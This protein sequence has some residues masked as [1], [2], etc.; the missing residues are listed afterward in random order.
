MLDTHDDGQAFM[1][2]INEFNQQLGDEVTGWKGVKKPERHA[3]QD[4]Y[5]ILEIMD[6]ERHAEQL[7]A[8]LTLNNKGDSW[9]YLPVGPF[10][11]CGEF[12]AWLKKFCSNDSTLAYVVLDIKSRLPVGMAGYLRIEPVHGVIEVGS[13]HYSKSFQCTAAATEAM[14]LMMA[15]VFD[16]LHYRRYEW[17]CNALNDA[18]RKAAV[19]LGFQFEGIF[20]QSNVFKKRNRDTAWYSIIDSEWPDIK[21]KLQRWLSPDNFDRD[22]RQIKKLG[23]ILTG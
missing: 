11:D 13:I 20:R 3:M 18:S 5:C 16:E 2:E 8:A 4:Q 23:E 9:T 22:G 7:Y 17:K 6:I 10:A 1:K 19:R 21:Q 15:H 14:Y 12:K